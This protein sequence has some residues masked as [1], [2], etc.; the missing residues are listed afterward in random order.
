MYVRSDVQAAECSFL[1]SWYGSAPAWLLVGG[2]PAVA[3]EVLQRHGISCILSCCD[4]L[5]LPPWTRNHRA[6][7]RDSAEERLEPF[8][9]EALRFLREAK[10]A[11]QKCLVACH[12][13]SSRSVT[14]VLAYLIMEEGMSLHNAWDLVRTQRG[15]AQPNRSFARQLIELDRAVHGVT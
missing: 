14:M 6:S 13:G 12:A 9:E 2:Q 4:R 5:P 11:Q 15:S 3:E 7:M 1:Q 10:A 8:L